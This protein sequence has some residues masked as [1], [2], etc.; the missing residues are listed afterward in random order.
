MSDAEITDS[1][2]WAKYYAVTA[3]RPA[4]GTVHKAIELFAA[5]DAADGR[6]PGIRPDGSPRLAVDLGCGAGRDVRALLRAGWR[7]I[8]VDSEPGA[9]AALETHVEAD[10]RP[11]LEIVIEDVSAFEIPACDLVNASVSL[12]FLPADAYAA[13]WRRIV[14]ALGHGGRLAAMIYGDRDQSAGEPGY[15]MVSLER[16]R[17][18]LDGFE[19]EDWVEREEETTLALGDPHHLHMFEF[20]ARRRERPGLPAIAGGPAGPIIRHGR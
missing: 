6:P 18:D 1:E 4:W 7:V 5:E 14:A 11:R 17:A 12:Q 19:I 13:T 2:Y 16:L 8:A 9:R 3:E 20:V 15:T 10:A